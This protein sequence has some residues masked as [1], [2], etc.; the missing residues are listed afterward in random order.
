METSESEITNRLE[1]V[2]LQ[3]CRFNVVS[4]AKE[5]NVKY[6]MKRSSTGGK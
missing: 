3:A 2:W 1:A 5:L 4:P 6:V